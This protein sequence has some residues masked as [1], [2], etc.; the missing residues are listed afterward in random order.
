MTQPEVSYAPAYY[1]GSSPFISAYRPPHPPSAPA[2]YLSEQS[3]SRHSQVGSSYRHPSEPVSAPD[4][5][6]HQS[7]PLVAQYYHS[8]SS[9]QPLRPQSD[10]PSPVARASF[11]SSPRLEDHSILTRSSNSSGAAAARKESLTHGSGSWTDHTSYMSNEN[12][13]SHGVS[14][15]HKQT[16]HDDEGS[17]DSSG[18]ED[19]LLM[20]VL[21]SFP[22]PSIHVD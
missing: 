14:R 5:P 20:L 2:A 7:S 17:A 1:Q 18:G 13:H 11:V 16:F 9:S 15:V 8:P 21:P 6:N 12:R 19:A 22:L 3:S 4:H 10:Q